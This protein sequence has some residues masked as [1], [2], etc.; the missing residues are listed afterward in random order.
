MAIR[1][2][3]ARANAT[4]SEGRGGRSPGVSRKYTKRMRPDS[5]PGRPYKTDLFQNQRNPRITLLERH[6][7]AALFLSLPLHDLFYR[8]HRVIKLA[9]LIYHRIVEL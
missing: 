8:M 3:T 5:L 2:W 6:D 4:S 7:T 9:V 1:L